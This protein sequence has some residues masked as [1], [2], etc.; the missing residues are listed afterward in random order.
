MSAVHH[1]PSVAPSAPDHEDLYGSTLLSLQQVRDLVRTVEGALALRHAAQFFVW[2]QGGLQ[3]LLPHQLLL[4]GAY[5]RASRELRFEVFNNAPVPQGLDL[6][7]CAP[8]SALSRRLQAEWLAH[9]EGRPLLMSAAELGLTG[10]AQLLIHGVSRPQRPSEIESFFALAHAESLYGPRQAVL[11]ELLMPQLHAGWLRVQSAESRSSPPQNAHSVPAGELTARECQVLQ[12]LR[13]GHSNQ[14][15]AQ[16]LDISALTV[17]N[18]VQRILRKL[19]AS[20]RAHAVARAQV[21]L[22]WLNEERG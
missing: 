7:L 9:G 11:L 12:G 18:H 1:D 15:I 4:C 10:Y 2:T 19:G 21:S 17:K 3:Q 5:H 8:G 16:T 13:Q 20:N 14:E 6:A 22:P